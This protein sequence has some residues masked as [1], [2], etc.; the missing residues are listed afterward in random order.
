MK[1]VFKWMPLA[2][3]TALIISGCGR[4]GYFY[5]RNEEYRSAE[6]SEPL[7]L[8]ETRERRRYQDSMPVPQANSDYLAEGDFDAPRPEPLSVGDQEEG[9]FVELREAGN[10]R[11]LL[12]SAAPA[13][14]W[15][16]LQGF[17]ENHGLQ[18]TALD[19]E[20][21]RIETAQAEL[22]VRQGLR[23]NTSEVRCEG[24]AAASGQCLRAL[25]GYLS[26]SAEEQE[27]SVS[28]AAQNL[29]RDDRVRLENRQGEWQ[30]W[31]AL[32]FERAWSEIYYQLESRFDEDGKRLLDQ[33]RSAGEF[34][35]EYTASSTA[36]GGFLGLFGG[37]AEP[38]E[39]RLMVASAGQ[40]STQ[41]RVIP[42]DGGPLADGEA[43]DV[44]DALAATLR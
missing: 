30:L 9:R 22:R 33:N 1:P 41:V 4:D 3:A 38:R 34:R 6:M 11:W 35:V 39:Y 29:A 20:N 28:L 12:V 19:A 8:P 42:S 5:D 36:G 31:L 27:R 7:R 40:G 44:L 23:G 16:Q 43:R 13:S 24:P 2:V 14:V 18:V 21:G 15:P 17:V 26:N 10:D 25:Q 37:D 32:D